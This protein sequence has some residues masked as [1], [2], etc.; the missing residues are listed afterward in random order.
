[1]DEPRKIDIYKAAGVLLKGRRFLIARSRDKIFFV[2]PGGKIETD[3]TPEEALL[4]ELREELG[5][6]VEQSSLDEFGTFYAQAAGETDRFL[7]MDVFL[8]NKWYGEIVPL[9]E[10]EEIMWIN[11]RDKDI[12]LGSVFQYDVLP[13]LKEMDLID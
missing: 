10:I 1:M 8:V 6:E 11:S 3:E 4:R 13:K 12:N 5:V 9:S 2:A 7:K